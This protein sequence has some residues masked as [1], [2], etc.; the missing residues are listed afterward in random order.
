[1]TAI[2]G[3]L[4]WFAGGP[5]GYMTLVHCMNHDY[6]W[7]AVT[8]ALDLMVAA[9]YVLIALHWRRNERALRD[10]PAKAALGTMK[11][12]FVFCGICGYLFI[13]IKMVWPAW[14]LYDGFLAVLVYYTWHYALRSRQLNVVYHELGRSER[15][16]DE[17]KSAREEGR[18]KS[19]F[20]NALSHD[21]KTPL[22]G[23]TLQAELATLNLD[24]GDAQGLRESLDQIK[25]CTKTTSEL[26]NSFLELGRIDWS[27]ESQRLEEIDVRELLVGLAGR[28]K[29]RAAANAGLRLEVE[30]PAEL[31]ICVRTG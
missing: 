5:D 31:S 2:R 4:D 29:P 22:N 26:L 24:T 11:T 1:M 10:S 13:P 15:L 18:R 3:L 6:V 16:A 30:S 28:S 19:Y 20:L 9:G 23:L 12:I 14:R 8:V 7:I 17:L 27:V 21:L 25:S